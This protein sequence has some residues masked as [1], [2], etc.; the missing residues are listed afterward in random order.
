[1]A[2]VCLVLGVEAECIQLSMT[3]C[4]AAKAGRVVAGMIRKLHRE[5]GGI[6]SAQVACPD[7]VVGEETLL[8]DRGASVASVVILFDYLRWQ[9]P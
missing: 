8:E 6:Q 7:M 5:L 1:V 4:S 2:V 3:P 9:S